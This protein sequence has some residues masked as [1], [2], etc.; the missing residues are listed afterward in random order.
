MEEVIKT[1]FYACL[2]LFIWK[3]VETTL[4]NVDGWLS[5]GE[6]W[7]RVIDLFFQI[8]Q[9]RESD[10]FE[11]SKSPN[12]QL[13]IYIVMAEICIHQLMAV[14][15]EYIFQLCC[16]FWGSTATQE[17]AGHV[18]WA[19]GDWRLYLIPVTNLRWSQWN[20][21]C[22]RIIE[23]FSGSENLISETICS[24]NGREL[25]LMFRLQISRC[26]SHL[27][28]ASPLRLSFQKISLDQKRTMVVKKMG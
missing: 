13:H 27:A 19:Q 5:Q 3:E 2:G 25:C 10:G 16:F 26:I 23:L 28:T 8:K 9:F 18:G 11:Q 1:E 21:S 20:H 7:K 17:Q 4:F 6:T 24:S 22:Q 15:G 14:K 12:P